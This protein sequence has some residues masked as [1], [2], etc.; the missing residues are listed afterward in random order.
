[1]K[2]I[3]TS[4]LTT[5]IMIGIFMVGFAKLVT[6]KEP[7]T[8]EKIAQNIDLETTKTPNIIIDTDDEITIKTSAVVGIAVEKAYTDGLTL[9]LSNTYSIGS[10]FIVDSTGY[11]ITNQHVIGSAYS[12]VYVT[13]YGGDTVNAEVIWANKD[14][15]LAI[16]KI[17]V[18]GLPVIELGDSEN[19][20]LGERVVAIG[21]PLGFEFQRTVTSGIISGLNRSMEIEGSYMEDLIQTDASINPGNSGG[22]LVNKEGRVIGINTIK[23]AS[24]EGIGFAIP[25]NQLKPII[26]KV[27]ETGTFSEISLGIKGL[28]REMTANMDSKIV[29]DKGIYVYEVEKNG[30]AWKAE[31][32]QGS[33][34]LSIDD[35]EI[36]T[37]AKMR[38]I[39]YG[40]ENGD[41]IKV[42]LITNGVE[43]KVEIEI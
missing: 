5:I 8:V 43:H 11:I 26:K 1:M 9:T 38:E 6:P 31:I 23:V 37:L 42:R 22:P 29:I 32:E 17:N 40:K 36:N 16:I 10:G 21:N 20:K 33:I 27:K 18:A 41:V 4:M 30:L 24:A 28:D 34:I 2:N 12:S 15:D 19:L 35:I 14:L 39:L 7:E 25:I 3:L 13:L